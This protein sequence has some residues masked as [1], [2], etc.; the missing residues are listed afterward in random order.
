MIFVG[1]DWADDHHDVVVMDE[2]GVTLAYRRLPEGVEGIGILHCLVAEHAQDPARV[3]V[4]IETD[5]GLWVGSLVAAGYQVY[6]VNP[7]VA[8]RYRERQSNSGAKSDRAD[9]KMLADLVR[10]DRHLHRQVA[11]DSEE[12]LAV[13]LLARSHQRLLWSRQRQLNGL[14][15]QL[16][17]Y[18]PAA[19]VAAGNDLAHH[20]ALAVLERAPRPEQGRSLSFSALQATLRRGGRRRNL[21]RRAQEIQQALR[22][23]QLETSA[24]VTRAYSAVGA[25]TI[26]V[27]AEMTRQIKALEAELKESFESRPDADILTSLPGLGPI[28]GARVLGEFG[29]DPN[30]YQDAR[31]RKNYAGTAPIT[32]ASGTKKVVLARFVR[33]RHLG[34]ATYLWAFA[35]LN[36]SPGAR[37]Y[38]ASRRAKGDG[39]NCALRALANRLVGILH[40]CL[41]HREAYVEVQAWG[42][43]AGYAPDGSAQAA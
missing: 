20:D 23:P 1:D 14:R 8:S 38:Y 39:H 2:M 4:G 3:V 28:L 35:S 30:R 11:G 24:T 36:S 26:A 5:R 12:V 34:D 21:E 29:D 13:Q 16:K 25:S 31:S 19:L 15:A 37:A 18:Y 32:R 41:A 33:N 27:I 22:A 7:K 6:A 43:R 40:G 17:E 10:T 9:A 42:H